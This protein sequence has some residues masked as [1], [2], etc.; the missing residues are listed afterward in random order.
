MATTKRYQRVYSYNKSLARKRSV[1]RGSGA[2]LGKRENFIF[3]SMSAEVSTGLLVKT[4]KLSLNFSRFFFSHY[5]FLLEIAE[6]LS[7]GIRLFSVDFVQV[8]RVLRICL[9]EN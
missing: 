8:E 7:F 1:S 5:I 6:V 2:D 9:F 3:V 4:S